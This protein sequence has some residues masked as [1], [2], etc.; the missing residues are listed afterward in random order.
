MLKQIFIEKRVCIFPAYEK[1]SPGNLWD[2][3]LNCLMFNFSLHFCFLFHWTPSYS[4]AM[5]ERKVSFQEEKQRGKAARKSREKK[6]KVL[7]STRQLSQSSMDDVVCSLCTLRTSTLNRMTCRNQKKR[8]PLRWKIPRI[9]RIVLRWLSEHAR[10]T[11]WKFIQLFHKFNFIVARVFHL[12]NSHNLG[13][14]HFSARLRSILCQLEHLYDLVQKKRF[15][16][17]HSHRVNF[18]MRKSLAQMPN[19]RTL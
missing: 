13:I 4:A 6:Q 9:I 7:L 14:F 16:D 2:E 10:R 8:N 15:F 1:V 3:I 12:Q 17:C 19:I 5:K 11:H 18:K